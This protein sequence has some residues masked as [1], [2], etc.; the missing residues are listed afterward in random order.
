MPRLTKSRIIAH[1]QCPKRLWLQINQ[2]ELQQLG[3]TAQ[4][5]VQ[6]GEQVTE[7]ARALH[8]DGVLLPPSLSQAL[9]QTQTWL[10]KRKPPSLFEAAFSY[11]DVCVRAD[12]LTPTPAGWSMT[13]VKSA[14]SLKAYYPEDAAVQAWV[15]ENAGLPLA[16]IGIAYINTQF[17]Y[18]GDGDF[19]GLFMH[20]DVT[21][22][23]R[24][25]QPQVVAW[26]DAANATL[27]RRKAP[28]VA[29]GRQC[30]EPYVCEFHAHCNPPPA[31]TY[32]VENLPA[33]HAGNLAAELRAEG[34]G[35]LR[36]V[37]AKR[38]PAKPILQRVHAVTRSGKAFLDPA[39]GQALAKLPYPRYY[40]DFETINPAV[41]IW[42]QSRPYQQIPFQWS[43][44]KENAAGH[45]THS[46]YLAQHEGDP[47]PRFI[48][49]LLAATGRRG[50]VFVYSQSFEETRLKELARDFPEHQDAIE[51]L[52][53]RLVDLLPMARNHYYHRDQQ[54]SWSIKAVLPTI[55][56]ELDYSA[57][58]VGNGGM[59]MEAFHEI[60][61]PET[62]ATRRAQL[63]E[64]LLA[65][66]ERD[67][68]AMVRIAQHF[69]GKAA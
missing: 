51:A 31:E 32:P 44:H 3:E 39:A 45:L 4:R 48:E 17:V 69:A 2:P 33:R 26:V 68:L 15:T 24:A 25:C 10:G 61:A 36:K 64:A 16:E 22:Q 29:P 63:R 12:V 23:V 66:C 1:R 67:T 49:T 21:E 57:L 40:I 30:S 53:S 42:A 9:A 62:N 60:L 11:Q 35:D 18:R 46:A 6:A 13:E 14:S 43:C 50:P 34:Y 38:I 56:P 20:V 27:A 59:A 52:I 55:A 54:G 19:R 65:Y 47:R 58:A 5:N 37:P 8:A 28:A 41:P 7:I